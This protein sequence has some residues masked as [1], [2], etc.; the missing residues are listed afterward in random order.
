MVKDHSLDLAQM[1][2]GIVTDVMGSGLTARTLYSTDG[3]HIIM[4]FDG[5]PLFNSSRRGKVFVQ[6]PRSTF[7]VRR[8]TVHLTPIQQ[9]QCRYYQEE[10]GRPLAHPH[11]FTDG[12]PCWSKA[13][14]LRPVDFIANI[15]ETLSLQNVTE[16]SVLIGLCANSMMG[17]R[18]DALE[19]AKVQQ[20]KVIDTLRC[21]PVI[22]DRIKLE[23]YID[24]RWR[25]KIDVFMKYIEGGEA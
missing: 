19:N 12:H 5:Y 10:L 23:R 8:G 1:A 13:E 25:G 9:A 22:R 14:R 11:I 21:Q 2:A 16:A 4:E 20:E 3:N 6:F 18:L 15:I 17:M 24:K 7:Y